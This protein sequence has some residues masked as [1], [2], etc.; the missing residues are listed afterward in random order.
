MKFYWLT[1]GALAVWR[2][3]HML[4]HEDGPWEVVL[5][6]RQAAGSGLI[7]SV[8]DC[9]NCL[10]VWVALPFAFALADGWGE[11]ILLWFA[12]SGAAILAQRATAPPAPWFKEEP[13]PDMEAHDG[14][15]RKGTGTNPPDAPGPSGSEF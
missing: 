4:A 11:F 6:L 7:A 5:H 12:L 10:S 15:L 13:T 9:F 1:I 8:M 14:L 2:I 3:T